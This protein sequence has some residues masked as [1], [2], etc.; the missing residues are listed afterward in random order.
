M[1]RVLCWSFGLLKISLLVVF[2]S[3]AT[4]GNDGIWQSSCICF[5]RA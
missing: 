2:K 4:L 5:D 1:L 3:V